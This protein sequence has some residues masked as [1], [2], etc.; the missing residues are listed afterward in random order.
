MLICARCLCRHTSRIPRHAME[1]STR[2]PIVASRY[3]ER[4]LAILAHLSPQMAQ[5][6]IFGR[7]QFLCSMQRSTIPCDLLMIYN[8]ERDGLEPDIA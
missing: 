3:F 6:E 4:L 5:E 8:T 1:V 7:S 2:I